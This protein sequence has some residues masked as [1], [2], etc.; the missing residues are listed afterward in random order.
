MRKSNSAVDYTPVDV[1]HRDPVYDLAFLQSKTGAEFMTTSTDGLVMFWDLRKMSEPQETLP[2]KDKGAET[3][4]GGATIEY[5][6]TAGPTKF[7]IGTE[8]GQ[9]IICNRKAKT[10]PER[11]NY[12][13]SGASSGSS[14]IHFSR[15][16]LSIAE[17]TFS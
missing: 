9:I 16:S 4:Q 2:L 8:Q 17:F 1:C 10:P 5:E 3:L 13:L 6:S 15:E 12:A 7:M 14:R 11:I